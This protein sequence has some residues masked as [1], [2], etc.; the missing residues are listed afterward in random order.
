MSAT[1]NNRLPMR[2]GE[3]QQTANVER[4]GMTMATREER[5]N[6]LCRLVRWPRFVRLVAGLTLLLAVPAGAQDHAHREHDGATHSPEPITG[7]PGH[8]MSHHGMIL[9][10]L[11]RF[12]TLAYDDRHMPKPPAIVSPPAHPGDAA[13]GKELAYA[14][15][16]GNCLACHVLE[17][18]GEQP[19]S[20]GPNLS[21]YA[22]L[23]RTEA[24][25]F[26]QVW[27]ARAHNAKTAMPPFGTNGILSASEM[28]DIVAYLRTLKRASASSHPAPAPGWNFAVAGDD[29]SL[30]DFYLDQGKALFEQAG[31]NGKSCAACHAG[32]RSLRGTATRYPVYDH[33]AARPITL[34]ERINGCRASRMT[35]PPLAPG[36]EALN[37]VSGYVKYLSRG[38][39][40]R[41]MAEGDGARRALVRGEALFSKKAGR[42]NLA[43]ADCHMTAAGRWLRGQRLIAIHADGEERAV[44]TKYPTHHV[45]R[46]ELG[47]V[48]LQQRIEHCQ[49]IT[50][51]LPLKPGS[52]EYTDLEYYLT[53][54][55]VGAPVLAPT[56]DGYRGG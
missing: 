19:G 18:D 25:T 34:E 21:A 15:D 22:K 4:V 8:T 2:P 35:L 44:A 38:M 39:P 7:V 52:R 9:H 3:K 46:H 29:L 50:Q 49:A 45:G 33:A 14:S 56:A 1:R 26:Q 36:S 51:V 23:G 28:A 53:W 17:A 54:L 13:R 43:C 12:P 32:E 24:Y 20:V 41:V 6:I 40:V 37:A 55:A 30:A 5:H 10:G 11:E 48:N 47:F 16:K 42:L 31:P 27:D